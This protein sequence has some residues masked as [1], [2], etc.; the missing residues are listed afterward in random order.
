[1]SDTPTP[2]NYTLLI[3]L[4]G[5]PLMSNQLLRGHWRKKHGHA[6]KW[7][8]AVSLASHMKRPRDPLERA[9]LTLTRCSSMRPDHDGLVSGFKS[10]ID[11]LVE[12]G[13]LANDKFENIGVPVY[14][15]AKAPLRKGHVLIEVLE[16]TTNEG[17]K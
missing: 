6:L 17:V 14:L 16:V 8:L 12:C 4:E 13:V 11:G 10:V 7:K 1:M 3:R 2:K 15:W 5:L 9:T